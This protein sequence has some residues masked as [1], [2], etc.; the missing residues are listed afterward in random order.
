MVPFMRF[1]AFTPW[2]ILVLAFQLSSPA[3]AMTLLTLEE[4]PLGYR[5][6]VGELEGISIDLVRELQRRV[7]NKD[8]IQLYPWARAYRIAKTSS[9]V[10]LFTVTRNPEREALFHWLLRVNR[11]AWVLYGRRDQGLRVT[12]LDQAR[13]SPN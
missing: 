13:Q 12:S 4:P 7:G 10:V 11:N 9:D 5:N 1:P 6:A 2:V 3:A 8:P